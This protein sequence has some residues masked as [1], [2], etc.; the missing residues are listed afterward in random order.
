VIVMAVVLL[1]AG[2]SL[3]LLIWF[4]CPSVIFRLEDVALP[5]VASSIFGFLACMWA[6]ASSTRYD[7][8]QA[9][10][11]S[12]IGLTLISALLYGALA[13][14]CQM[15]VRW[16]IKTQKWDKKDSLLAGRYSSSFAYNAS[17]Q[18]QQ[19]HHNNA[20]S[21]H[22]PLVQQAAG[23]SQSTPQRTHVVPMTEDELVS[24]QM[25]SLLTKPD[26]RP[27]PDPTQS[28]F[29]ISW[30]SGDIDDNDV[31]DNNLDDDAAR[32]RANSETRSVTF[33]SPEAAQRGER[34]R[35]SSSGGRTASPSSTT[36]L[37]IGQ[38]LGMD[39][40]GRQE[41]RTLQAATE[42]RKSREERRREIELAS[43]ESQREP[44]PETWI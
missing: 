12:M 14:V 19:P 25:A 26:S 27:S 44:E 31:N 20:N 43:L 39:G 9:G 6:L 41:R 37:R 22:Q 23:P 5:A 35:S 10:F 32:K 17:L 15:R 33:L 38:A 3:S 4:A 2:Y 8:T 21:I 28:T 16:V 36:L 7:P 29:K 1:I 30:P 42:R 40:R 13:V 34:R 18:S 11:A 24:Q